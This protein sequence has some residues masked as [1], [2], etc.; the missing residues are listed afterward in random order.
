MAEL[1]AGWGLKPKKRKDGKLDIVGKDVTGAE[2]VAR[3]TET[4]GVTERDLEIL[5]VGN[6]EQS[7][8]REFTEFYAN[9]R[10]TYK[11]NWETSIDS[12]YVEAAE[13]VTHA[14]LHLS[15]SRVGYSRKYAQ[16]FDRV[17]GKEN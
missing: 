1:P 15:E 13:Q 9:E 17:F 5:R 2:Y 14:G 7:N 4:E 10:R 3:T 12:E 16:N 11:K 6:R 8:A